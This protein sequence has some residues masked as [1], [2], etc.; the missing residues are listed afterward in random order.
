MLTLQ[1]EKSVLD[2]FNVQEP[3]RNCLRFYKYA[4]W[5]VCMG[6]DTAFCLNQIGGT[7][8]FESNEER[9]LRQST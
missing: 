2:T 4:Y 1:F 9:D 8:S 3:T 6:D 7:H 5:I